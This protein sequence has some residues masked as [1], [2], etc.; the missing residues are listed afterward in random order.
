[1]NFA[2]IVACAAGA[3]AKTDALTEFADQVVALDTMD[4][5][6]FSTFFKWVSAS[7]GSG[8]QS[9]GAT[10]ELQ[11]PPPPAEVEVVL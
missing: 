4:S 2:I 8:N 7:I 10:T 9:M 5:A 11:L 1:M 3:K 6:S